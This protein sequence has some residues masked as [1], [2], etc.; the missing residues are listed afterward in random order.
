[1]GTKEIKW[2][3]EEPISPND[4]YNF[5]R[6]LDLADTAVKKVISNIRVNPLSSIAEHPVIFGDGTPSTMF[7]NIQWIQYV[8]GVDDENGQIFL[9]PKMMSHVQPEA[10]IIVILR[11]PVNMTF[12]SYKFFHNKDT[13]MAINL[14]HR[15][16]IDSLQAYLECENYHS[17]NYCSYIQKDEFNFTGDFKECSFVLRSLQLGRYYIFMHEWLKYFPRQQVFV[18]R[19]S[20][21]KHEHIHIVVV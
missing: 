7:N 18:I 3:S 12:S 14:F 4:I 11:D 13:K 1:M 10:K 21:L 19:V 15:C 6:Y 5:E 20:I 8:R 2:W 16:V 17:I 9:T